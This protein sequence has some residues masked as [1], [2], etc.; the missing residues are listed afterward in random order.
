V[1][2]SDDEPHDGDV[3]ICWECG[4]AMLFEGRGFRYPTPE[5]FQELMHDE[6]FVATMAKVAVKLSGAQDPTA[7]IIN[8]QGV[9]TVIAPTPDAIC[10]MCGK[11]DELRPYGPKNGGVRMKVCF[12]CAHKNEDE[13]RR[14]FDERIEGRNPV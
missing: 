5:E 6:D 11:T 13:L 9:A 1:D 12:S 2:G 4:E 7:I 8:D 10:E 3:A 14:A